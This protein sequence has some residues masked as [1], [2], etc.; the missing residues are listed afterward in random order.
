VVSEAIARSWYLDSWAPGL[1]SLR[2]VALGLQADLWFQFNEE[3]QRCKNQAYSD[4]VCRRITILPCV[5]YVYFGCIELSLFSDGPTLRDLVYDL[6]DTI[7][8]VNYETVYSSIE[9]IFLGGV[10]DPVNDP[11]TS[12]TDRRPTIRENP[13]T[14]FT[15]IKALKSLTVGEYSD[16]FCM[17]AQKALLRHKG[18]ISGEFDR[19]PPF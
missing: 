8:Y 2:E 9:H 11:A 19:I 7:R 16:G 18:A 4:I 12:A 17:D 10:A 3:F 1:R 6:F 5:E 15:N 13:E 14:L